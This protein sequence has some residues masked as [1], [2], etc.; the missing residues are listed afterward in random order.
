MKLSPDRLHEVLSVLLGQPKRQCSS[1]SLTNAGTRISPVLQDRLPA[2]CDTDG[3]S[4][5]DSNKPLT[6][7]ENSEADNS[8]KESSEAAKENP[9][10]VTL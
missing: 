5:G 7:L 3:D 9:L 10:H 1:Q 6:T 8:T 2:N 4:S